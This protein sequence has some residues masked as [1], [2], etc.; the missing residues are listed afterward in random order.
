MYVLWCIYLLD[1]CLDVHRLLPMP[2]PPSH[3]WHLSRW[4]SPSVK[5]YGK[6]FT[7]V[8]EGRDNCKVVKSVFE[9]TSKITCP[10][11]QRLRRHCVR[12]YNCAFCQNHIWSSCGSSLLSC[13]TEKKAACH[14]D[15]DPDCKLWVGN[16]G[17]E[18]NR[19]GQEHEHCC[20]LFYN[21]LFSV[22]ILNC[23]GFESRNRYI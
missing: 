6:N 13:T 1:V 9:Y 18:G 2:L 7:I 12:N 20:S 19:W 3:P 5:L 14:M 11:S 22:S 10:F 21:V 23:P 8:S 15:W 16:L 17:E 4:K